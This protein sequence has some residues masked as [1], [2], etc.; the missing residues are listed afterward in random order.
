MRLTVVTAAVCLAVV[1]LSVA[2]ESQASV[3]KHTNIPAEDLGV[4]LQT[5]AKER[6]FQVVYETEQLRSIKTKGVSGDLTPEEA[7]TH[8]LEGTGFTYRY[9]NDKGV[10]IVPVSYTPASE[11]PGMG[12]PSSNVQS[13][14]SVDG[15]SNTEEGKKGILDRFRVAQ[16]DQGMS[17]SSSELNSASQS[18]ESSLEEIVVT[19][20]KRTER[21]QDV[22]MGVG[23]VSGDT[24]T[25]LNMTH[26]TDMSAM[27][28][29]LEVS[30]VAGSPGSVTVT[31]RGISDGATGSSTATTAIYI[32]NV[33]VSASSSY[34]DGGADTVDLFPFDLDR[35]EVLQGPQGT[36]YGASSLGGV[37]K[38]VLLSPDLNETSFKVGGLGTWTDQGSQEGW[39]ARARG[40]FVLIPGQL[41]ISA[42]GARIETPGYIDNAVTNAHDINY[43]TQTG[44][45]L[46]VLW[47]PI[48]QLS[49]KLG[50]LRSDS[51]S[52]AASAIL[53][54]PKT[55]QPLYGKY[56]TSLQ[57]STGETTRFTLTS[58]EI[59]YNFGWA[60]LTSETGYLDSYLGEGFDGSPLFAYL[61][62]LD[63]FKTYIRLDKFSQEIRLASPKDRRL[64]WLI[65]AFFDDEKPSLTFAGNALN[66]ATRQ[67]N[68][69]YNP[70]EDVSSPSTYKEGAVFGNLTFNVTDAWD[71][72]P[73][74]RWS[75]SSQSTTTVG[76]GGGGYG[77]FY[78][79][80]PIPYS[81]PVYS[82]SD[83]VGT[84]SFTT[85]YH[86]TP[87][88]MVYARVATGFRPGG[89]NTNVGAPPTF[90]PDRLT[91]YE[92]GLKSELLD[93]RL[94]FNV[95]AFYIDW[96]NIQLDQQNPITFTSFT[97]N[98]GAAT[99]KGVELTTA[100]AITRELRVGINGAYTDAILTTDDPEIGA[101]A[102]DPLPNQPKLSGAVHA[103]WRHPLRDNYEAKVG[104]LWRYVGYRY[105]SFPGNVNYL[106]VPLPSYDP[107]D[108]SMSIGNARW[109]LSVFA[110]NLANKYAYTSYSVDTASLLPPRTV[111]ISVDVR[112]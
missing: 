20:Q 93:R 110:R 4:A 66:P 107:I 14:E 3:K 27:V 94:L 62:V 80:S 5:L 51:D 82:S 7:L 61:G 2:G 95:D 6:G 92:V 84:Y 75:H 39:G 46:S 87:D 78:Y 24:V 38:Y 112:F 15:S 36:L 56:T 79:P 104:I 90:G 37:V 72:S 109:T 45:R 19:A 73:G 47:Q 40:N 97:G 105:S 12:R 35:M 49:V 23:V 111:G 21:L 86:I 71:V 1:G 89:A 65:G 10:S 100:Y 64:Q 50:I 83:G 48:D 55:G 67:P 44:G 103:D 43:N 68:P 53:L 8:L 69:T 32:D 91:N 30:S 102:G 88:A 41:A 60:E 99:S 52:N 96:K 59:N 25:A 29:G 17:T 57:E 108:L 101:H 81:T 54:D 11:T 22:P 63:E 16:V 106:S 42:S 76:E 31:L 34:A 28:P 18:S 98:A 77:G 85:R 33:P 13:P 74:V 26:L 58:A 9:L 70:L